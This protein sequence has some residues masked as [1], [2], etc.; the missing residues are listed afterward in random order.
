[1]T[2]YALSGYLGSFMT[3]GPFIIVPILAYLNS[4]WWFL[5]GILFCI[6]G[7]AMASEKYKFVVLLIVGAIFFILQKN[8]FLNNT[9]IFLYLCFLFNFSLYLIYRLI[10]FSDKK[11]RALIA[12]S[13][14]RDAMEEIRKEAD[15]EIKKK[16][17]DG[18]DMFHN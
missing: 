5:F 8:D 6:I 18:S 12:A 14:N 9:L 4:N 2:R 17:P 1:M 7:T 13:G 15:I 16:F 11:T 10:G 3:F